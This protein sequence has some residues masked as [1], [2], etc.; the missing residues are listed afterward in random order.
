MAAAYSLNAATITETYNF[1]ADT[2]TLGTTQS[3]SSTP[4]G[5]PSVTLSGFNNASTAVATDLF[6]K[7][8]ASPS[9]ENGVGLN[10]DTDGEITYGSFVQIDLEPLITG[11]NSIANFNLMFGSTTLG[12]EWRVCQTNT[13]GALCGTSADLGGATNPGTTNYGTFVSFN[14]PTDRYIDVTEAVNSG[15][16]NILLGKLKVD[17]SSGSAGGASVPEP[18][19]LGLAGFALAG[20]GLLRLRKRVG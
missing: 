13:A 16:D 7:S 12:E 17:V 14:T 19:T 4:S 10:N 6:G 8:T 11:G 9:D 5:G 18:A 20:L 3:Y 15:D 1:N 2:G